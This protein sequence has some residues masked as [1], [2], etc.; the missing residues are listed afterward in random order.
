MYFVAVREPLSRHLHG[1]QRK[2]WETERD[3]L[4]VHGGPRL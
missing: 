3:P 4:L 2:A 1:R